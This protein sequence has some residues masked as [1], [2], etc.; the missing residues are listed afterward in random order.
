M[1][2]KYLK[3]SAFG[4]YSGVEE[5]DFTKMDNGLFLINGDTGAGKTTI[6]DAIIFA[7]Y[8]EASG[9]IRQSN[10]LRSDFAS[11]DIDTYVELTFENNGKEYYISRS[12]EYLKKKK[13]G[14]GY[15]KK[16]GDATLKYPDGRIVNKYSAV[17]ENVIE[18]LGITKDQFTNIAMIAQ[19]DFLKLILAKTDERSKIFRNIFNT[20]IYLDIQFILKEEM[21]KRLDE[22]KKFE[23]SILQYERDTECDKKSEYYDVYSSMKKEK[24][25][26]AIDGFIEIVEKMSVEDNEIKNKYINFKEDFEKNSVIISDML[27]VLEEIKN[28]NSDIKKINEEIDENK[29]KLSLVNNEKTNHEKNRKIRDEKYIYLNDL[30]SKLGEYENLDCK[31]NETKALDK[32]IKKLLRRKEKE[33]DK[34]DTI[35]KNIKEYKDNQIKINEFNEKINENKLQLSDILVK[36]E[37]INEIISKKS[38][39]DK[40][41]KEYEKLKEKYVIIEEDARKCRL[42]S[43][44]L[45]ESFLREQ[46]G[47]L[48][49]DLKDGD[50]CPVC[51]STTHPQLAK[52]S[53]L[54][55]TQKDVNLAKDKVEKIVKQLEDA[56]AKCSHVNGQ[57]EIE[58]NEY[59]K[60]CDSISKDVDVTEYN[61]ILSAKNKYEEI[62]K[63]LKNENNRFIKF[64]GDNENVSEK[65]EECEKTLESIE[66]KITEADKSI[67]DINIKLAGLNGIISNIKL[68]LKFESKRKAEVEIYFL[69][70]FIEEH[71]NS[72]ELIDNT[73]NSLKEIS[74][75]NETKLE[76]FLKQ[77]KNLK[78]KL[79]CLVK[80]LNEFNDKLD[81]SDIKYVY[82]VKQTLDSEIKKLEIQCSIIEYRVKN[83]ENAINKIKDIL[84]GR[85][86]VIKEYLMYQKLCNVANGTISGKDKITFERYVQGTYFEYIIAAANLRLKDMT[87]RR[88][89]LLKRV[90]NN[91]RSQSG[92]ELDIKDAYTGKVRSINTLSGG[93]AFKASLSMALGLSDVVQSYAGGIRLDSMFIDEGFGSLDKESLEKAIQILNN[94]SDGK[95]MIGIISHVGE[96]GDWIDKKIKISKSNEGSKIN[97]I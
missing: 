11:D 42:E 56:S 16:S 38:S 27:N 70:R 9:N 60:K 3:I 92:L 89:E 81:W 40:L 14:D 34:I 35:K 79:D 31:I 87:D 1:K 21:M 50:A 74:T 75:T 93:E 4:P 46:A 88:Y 97:Q 29:E 6:F 24:N 54:A 20:K 26:N 57:L 55:P 48:A 18:I 25:I 32:E 52:I 5:V 78:D 90:D 83:N 17:T 67:V 68:K 64:I 69:K 12:P 73:I 91:L 15:T 7:L 23:D 86:K 71:D 77:E 45:E 22:N 2:P 96:L 58:K 72:C 44:I 62:I 49:S 41:C 39:I 95:R 80:K 94:L 84:K 37:I 33:S 82:Y 8:G 76:M 10:M 53:K 65:L 63:E 47:I 19:G 13:K 43:A 30:Q 28:C 61:N 51:G 66:N 85:E 36:Y 59:N